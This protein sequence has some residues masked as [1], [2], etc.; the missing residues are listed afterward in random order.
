MNKQALL[1]LATR[2]V[3]DLKEWSEEATHRDVISPEE[4]TVL[5][6]AAET[7]D[8]VTVKAVAEGPDAP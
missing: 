2:L 1:D 6:A 8:R 3:K 4:L 5:Q 7:V